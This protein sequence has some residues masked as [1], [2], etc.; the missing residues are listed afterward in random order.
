MTVPMVVVTARAIRKILIFL[1]GSLRTIPAI[2][3]TRVITLKSTSALRFTLNGTG[4]WQRLGG[5]ASSVASKR[6]RYKLIY[7]RRVDWHMPIRRSRVGL[8]FY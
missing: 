7:A 5:S 3:T 1:D 4:S 2:A 8:G 6:R